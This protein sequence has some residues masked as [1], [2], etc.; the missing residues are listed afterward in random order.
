MST[1]IET[2]PA[3]EVRT[4]RVSGHFMRIQAGDE[5]T[6][7]FYR[8]GGVIGRYEKTMSGFAVKFDS[9]YD[10]FDL[11]NTGSLAAQ[12]RIF[13]GE[14]SGAD[15]QF[16]GLTG[17][18][19][20]INGELSRVKA[21]E[22][23]GGVA[24]VAPVAA[25]YSH[26]QIWNPVGSTKTIVLTKVHITSA[27]AVAVRFG[28]STAA[29]ATPVTQLHGR[30]KNIGGADSVAEMRVETNAAILVDPSNRFMTLALDTP[31]QVLALPFSEPIVIPP[32][33]GVCCAC[34][35]VNTGLGSSFQWIEE[36]I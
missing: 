12:T 11:E 30:N 15:V 32:G 5:L 16:A 7:T 36:A 23:F 24:D 21:G 4:Y 8:N 13:L 18:V 22:A 3:G 34:V 35:S 28:L 33:Y 2:I 10:R 17:T 19:A 31:N 25:T 20:V 14:E 26:N 27:T 1:I 29:L 9:G 6:A